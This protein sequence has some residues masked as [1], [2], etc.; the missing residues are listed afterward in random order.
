MQYSATLLLR[1][2]TLGCELFVKNL[3]AGYGPVQV[4]HEVNLDVHQAETVV[5]LGTNGNGKSTL[6]KSVM[7]LVPA[8]SG[9]VLARIDGE[10]YNLTKLRT[11]EIVKL[12]ICLVP[13]GRHLF[14]RLSVRKNLMLGSYR[15]AARAKLQETLALVFE[16]FPVLQER[17][18]QMA[19]SMS[20]GEQQMV[21]LGRVLMSQPRLLLIDEPSVGLAP[22]YVQK[23]MSQ[24]A[25]L[26]ERI[27]LTVLMAAQNFTQAIRV[28][29][30]GYV[31]VH[32]QIAMQASATELS[33]SDLIR[34]HYM[35][36]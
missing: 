8:T 4:L 11:E 20:G 10:I 18:H 13:E 7:G 5:L 23:V 16:I 29:D 1:G 25:Q 28:A 17:Q 2:F 30:R 9:E 6:M 36:A 34:Q 24:I 19:G 12:G 21:A 14:P 27:G 3:C 32:G 26:K 31:I 22:I 15:D 33:H 35:G